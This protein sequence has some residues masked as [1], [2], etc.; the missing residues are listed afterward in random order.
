MWN[1][2]PAGS[3]VSDAQR[4]CLTFL[5]KRAPVAV[6]KAT[7]DAGALTGRGRGGGADDEEETE[8]AVYTGDQRER[9]QAK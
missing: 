3:F 4:S 8:H 9:Q 7:L 2:A 1:N 6:R 5:K